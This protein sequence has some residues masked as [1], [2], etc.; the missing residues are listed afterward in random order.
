MA[1]EQITD[2]QATRCLWISLF[3]GALIGGILGV[4]RYGGMP[5]GLVNP[6]TWN[7]MGLFMITTVAIAAAWIAVR[8]RHRGDDAG[9]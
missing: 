5:E 4:P 7:L 2:K 3:V 6:S 1:N 8:H 9:A